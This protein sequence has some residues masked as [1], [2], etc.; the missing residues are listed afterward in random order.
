MLAINKILRGRYRVIQQLGRDEAGTVYKAHDNVRDTNVALKEIS[1]DWDKVS[2]V[3]EKELLKRS[4]ADQAKLLAKV[5][6]ES[7][8]Q[9][10]GFFSEVDRQYLVMELVDGDDARELLAKTKSPLALS[11]AANWADQLLDALDYLHTLAP[12]VIHCNIKPQNVKLTSRGKIK[13][14]DFGIAQSAEAKINTVAA[15]ETSAATL[16]YS[17]LEQILQLV[18]SSALEEI[19]KDYAE[20]LEEVLRQTADARSDVYALGA[21]LYHLLTAQLPVDALD[22]ALAVWAG[23]SDSLPSPHQV[24]SSVPVEVSDFLMKALEIERDERFA[25]ATEMRQALQTAVETAKKRETEDARSREEAEKRELLLAEE[26]KLEQERK[27]VEEERLQLEAEQKKQKE[28]VA[29]Q[30]KEAE[31]QRLEAEKRAAEAEK[32]L[33]EKESKNADGEQSPAIAES[34]KN[35][36]QKSAL[37]AASSQ[38]SAPDEIR[39]LFAEPKKDNNMARMIPVAVV[40]FLMLGGG[41][42]GIWA[43][44]K[45]NAV[46]AN[47]SVSS[48]PDSSVKKSEPEPIAADTPQPETVA[49]PETTAMT[50]VTTASPSVTEASTSRSA[51]KNKPAVAAPTPAPRVEKQAP[52][53]AI[54]AQPKPKKAVTVDD[55]IGGN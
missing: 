16:P 18:D 14:L 2:T 27:R 7:L 39:D 11:D 3:T 33:L 26:K 55:L 52:P 4:F 45:S 54:K 8:P 20:E 37:A 31:A 49:T 43:W 24:N 34:A 35:S 53:P 17:P 22:R 41:I 36:T 47:Q 9:I 32:R 13:L 50:N 42:W 51:P 48:Q 6:H 25:S 23:K 29:R 40:I 10:L 21:T 46:E 5:K 12:P 38:N 28:A 15:S 19:R 1:V 44:Q 30:L